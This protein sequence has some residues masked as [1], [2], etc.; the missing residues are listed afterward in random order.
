[1]AAQTFTLS[2]AETM[3]VQA[4]HGA[5]VAT[6]NVGTPAV[7]AAINK[8]VANV[9]ADVSLPEFAGSLYST[10]ALT[11]TS[12]SAPLPADCMIPIGLQVAGWIAVRRSLTEV[13]RINATPLGS[14]QEGS[15]CFAGTTAMF[16]PTPASAP[17]YTLHYIAIPALLTGAS[18]PIEVSP[19]LFTPIWLQAALM[20]LGQYA[21][22]DQNEIQRL[23]GRYE[24]IIARLTGREDKE[25]AKAA[26]EQARQRIR[27]GMPSDQSGT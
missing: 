5:G 11:F 15:Y 17:T 19:Q 26:S 12:G 20:C 24:S 8:A 9:L 21:G 7:D 22:A 14:I 18:D 13:I 25:L 2:D 23:T 6:V 1:M 4:I 27:I 10:S 16:A 3:V